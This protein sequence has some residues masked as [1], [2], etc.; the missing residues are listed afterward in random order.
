MMQVTREMGSS[1]IRVQS[2]DPSSRF[3]PLNFCKLVMSS[4]PFNDLV[5]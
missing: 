3:G 4:D 2:S 5:G 1:I